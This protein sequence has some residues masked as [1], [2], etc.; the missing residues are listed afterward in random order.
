M[1]EV[2]FPRANVLGVGVHAINMEQAVDY[3]LDVVARRQRGYVCVTGVHGVM[4]AQHNPRFRRVL[5]ESLLT[6]PD[7]MP[8]VWVG[9]IEGYRQMGRVFGPDL[10]LNMCRESV[11]RGFTHFLYGGIPGVAERLKENLEA[12]FPG[13]KIVGTCTPPFHPLHF[14]EHCELCEQVSVVKPDIFWV[15]LSTPKQERFMADYFDR[16]DTRLMVGVGAAFDLLTGRMADAPDWMKKAGL[17]WAHRLIQDPRRLW[18]RYLV[19]NPK[20]LIA[21]TAQLLGLHHYQLPSKCKPIITQKT[22]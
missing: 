11:K 12:R 19:N 22:A 6:T 5:N 18:H 9:K 10:M 13:I 20:F 7:G 21:I 4:E 14:D 15:G 2:E 16:L 3:L 17:Q 1:T 8:T